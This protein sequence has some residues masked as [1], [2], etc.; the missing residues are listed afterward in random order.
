MHR[1]CMGAAITLGESPVRLSRPQS[2]SRGA[3]KLF[4][5]FRWFSRHN[6]TCYPKQAWIA[7]KLRASIGSVRRW[8]AELVYRDLVS[9]IPRGPRGSVYVAVETDCEMDFTNDTLLLNTEIVKQQASRKP[10]AKAPAAHPEYLEEFARA[11]RGSVSDHVVE[12]WAAA[13]A[14]VGVPATLAGDF[15]LKL[16]QQPRLWSPGPHVR[17]PVAYRAAAVERE[18]LGIRSIA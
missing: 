15:A 12:R 18:L 9:V 6:W 8:L 5:L 16:A 4:S 14:S 13:S 1:D 10:P 11:A 2:V 3:K 7:A 17:H